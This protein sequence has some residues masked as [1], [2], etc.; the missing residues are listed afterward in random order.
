MTTFALALSLALAVGSEDPFRRLTFDESLAAAKREH[1]VV[2]I[3]FFTTWCVPCKRLDEVTW[4]DPKVRN[5]ISEKTVAIRIDAERESELASRFLIHSYPTIVFVSEDGKRI[6]TLVG[7]KAPDEFLKASSDALAGKNSEARA[8]EELIG[9]DNDP[10]ARA[11][12]GSELA[13]NGKYEEALAEYLW[14]FDHGIEAKS[15]YSAIRSSFLLSDIVQLGRL[16]PRALDAL[17]ER[18]DAIESRILSEKGTKQDAEDLACI[19]R[20]LLVPERTMAVYDQL[21]KQHLLSPE[22]GGVLVGELAERLVEARRWKDILEDGGDLAALAKRDIDNLKGWG[23]TLRAGESD[24]SS[25]DSPVQA[26]RS[27]TTRRVGIWF[28]ALLAT[29]NKEVAIAVASDL[30]TVLPSGATYAAL[31]DRAVHAGANDVARSLSE[32]ARTTLVDREKA[33][34]EEAAKRIPPGG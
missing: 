11:K 7:F 1:K 24:S 21:K 29:G 33:T 2:M 18:R 12:H 31:I 14:C 27:L 3:D 8:R 26:R 22:V 6:D 15:S 4:A 20:E 32:R 9:R 19:N 10:T 34:A 30:L 25:K 23:G 13:R 17:R 28:E 5:W 16:Y